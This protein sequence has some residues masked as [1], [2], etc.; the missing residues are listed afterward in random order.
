MAG[1]AEKMIVLLLRV[2]VGGV[3]FYAGVLK[4]MDP[5]LFAKDV[6]NYRL[7]PI[8]GAAAVAL[9]LPWLE[10]FA[11]AALA[12]G[13]WG[14]GASLVIAGLLAAFF[15]AIISAWMRGLDIVCGCFGHTAGKSNYPLSLLIDAALFAALCIVARR[16]Q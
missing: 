13:V 4:A 14:R 6:D 1:R 8:A 10:I 3:F 5:A 2:I 16:S 15:I 9:Y 12:M 11:G 7:L